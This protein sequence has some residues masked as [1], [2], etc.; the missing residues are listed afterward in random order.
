MTYKIEGYIT[1]LAKVNII[2]RQI[3]EQGFIL[4][5]VGLPTL[6]G[7]QGE[8]L[9]ALEKEMIVSISQVNFAYS[10]LTTILAIV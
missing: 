6:L 5:P 7:S 1:S 4:G 3:K 2:S 9:V 8:G 10:V